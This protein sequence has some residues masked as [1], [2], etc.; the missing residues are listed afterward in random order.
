[1]LNGCRGGSIKKNGVYEQVCESLEKAEIH[2]AEGW[3]VQPNPTLDKVIEL[4][5]LAKLEK[6]EAILGV[7]GGSVIDTAKTVSAGVFTRYLECFFGER[8][9]S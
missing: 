1:M 9:N 8:K 2:F 6:V 5:E 7:G 4:C 3:E